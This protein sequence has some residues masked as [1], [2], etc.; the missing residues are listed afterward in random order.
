MLALL[1]ITGRQAAL[2]QIRAGR[3][4][5]RTLRCRSHLLRSHPTPNRRD[6][7]EGTDSWHCPR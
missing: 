3:S 2:T 1:G 4:N 6:T 7:M 5:L